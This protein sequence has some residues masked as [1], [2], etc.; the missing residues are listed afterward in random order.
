LLIE[1]PPPESS[2]AQQPSP[3][4]KEEYM[5]KQLLGRKIPATVALGLVLAVPGLANADVKFNFT[6]IDY[7][8]SS[9][10]AANGNSPNAIV[11]EFDDVGGA[12]HGFVLRG[13]K[14]TQIDVPNAT[15][16]AVNGINAS[17]QLS[18]TYTD[19]SG[20][21][22]A[23]FSSTGS[24]PFSTLDPP[25]DPPV[26]RSQGGFIN[27]QSQVVGTYRTVD[28]KRHGF[29]W[30]EG[31]FTTLNVPNDHPVF[32]TVA[33]GINDQE[34]VVGDYVDANDGVRRG[35]LLSKGTYTNFAAPGAI[36]T[37]AEGI[38]NSGVI[39]GLYMDANNAQHGFV[40]SGGSFTTIDFPKSTATE[41]FSINAQGQIVGNY[42]DTRGVT[43]GFLGVPEALP[44]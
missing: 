20:H 42:T 15:L 10:T 36:L 34:Q 13:G 38:N 2:A 40:K 44:Y 21:F 23:Y 14:F 19:A 43:H 9:R 26:V 29:I 28:Q 4:R 7:P 17:G 35:F 5:K 6:T 18:G 22:H 39:V 37:V 24:L 8:G 1:H 12:T 31:T 30:R 16:T 41:V 32:G 27:A 25:L 11:G 33:L 3:K